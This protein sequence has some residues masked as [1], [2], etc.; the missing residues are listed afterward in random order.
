MRGSS[1]TLRGATTHSEHGV[2][3]I[4]KVSAVLECMQAIAMFEGGIR[5]HWYYLPVLKRES[6]R[7]ALRHTATS[8]AAQ[9]SLGLVR[10][11]T[12]GP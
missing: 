3:S 8:G 12:K 2:T 5:P 4:S 9:S 6:H 1:C 7:L 10:R 11:P